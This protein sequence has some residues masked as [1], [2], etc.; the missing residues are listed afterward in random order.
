MVKCHFGHSVQQD[1]CFPCQSGFVQTLDVYW[2]ARA[3]PLSVLSVVLS[4]AKRTARGLR[5][6]APV[7]N[8]VECSSFLARAPGH[9]GDGRSKALGSKQSLDL[10][11]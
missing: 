4:H 11:G 5:S 10:K 8:V 3:V 6:S 1:I 9:E 7:L 2:K